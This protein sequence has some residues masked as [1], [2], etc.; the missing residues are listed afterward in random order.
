MS[1]ALRF[2]IL[3][4]GPDRVSRLGRMAIEKLLAS[5]CQLT[6]WLKG[7]NEPPLPWGLDDPRE[8]GALPATVVLI[9]KDSSAA[10]T[11]LNVAAPDFLLQLD[12]RPPSPE[13]S[14]V[15]RYGVWRFAS[16]GPGPLAF[17][18]GSPGTE[19]EFAL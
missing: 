11:A 5:G 8:L 6:I 3:G 10:L 15:P 18:V 13:L 19:L 2:G 17:W 7:E 1:A 12:E 4:T 14:K 16:G 9:T